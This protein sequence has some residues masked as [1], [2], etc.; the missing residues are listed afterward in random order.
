MASPSPSGRP[1]RPLGL[2]GSSA[3]LGTLP[4]RLRLVWSTVTSTARR[5]DGGVGR[6]ASLGICAVRALIWADLAGE[7]LGAVAHVPVVAW[8]RVLSRRHSRRGASRIS[9]PTHVVWQDEPCACA[10]RS[11]L[12]A[13]S[14]AARR[15]AR[16]WCTPGAATRRAT[17]GGLPHSPTGSAPPPAAMA[18]LLEWL[19]SACPA[20]GATVLDSARRT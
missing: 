19:E 7:L 17:L 5:L 11:S 10:L 3:L 6:S 18:P 15:R 1:G 8:I 2:P 16:K 9:S 14:A 20:R 4:G 12:L 13:P